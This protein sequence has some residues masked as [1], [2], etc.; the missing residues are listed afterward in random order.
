MTTT[1]FL[2]LS[3]SVPVASGSHAV[4]AAT[5][6]GSFQEGV[7]HFLPSSLAGADRTE[8]HS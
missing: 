6:G 8:Q 1:S 7:Q 2:Q 4:Q 5:G 3:P